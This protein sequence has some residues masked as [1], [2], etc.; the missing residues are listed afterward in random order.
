MLSS[1][2]AK[3]IRDRWIGMTIGAITMALFLLYGMAVYR[4]LDLS[5]YADMPES[6]RMLMNIPA[7]LDASQLAY[8]AVYG[9]V[10][11]MTLASLAIGMGSSSITGEE[12]KGTIGI[13][14]ANPKSRTH[15]LVS[16]AAAMLMITAFGAAILWAAGRLTPL[17][18]DVDVSAMQVEALIVHMYANAVFYGFLAMM[19]G[20]WSGKGT[21]ATGTAATV[22]VV[23]Y[24][25]VGILPLVE[26][27]EN[28]AKVF[29]WYYY[30]SSRPVDNG[31]DWGHLGVL[32][33]ATAVFAFV[34]YVG[35][36]RRDLRGPTTGVTLLDRLRNHPLTRKVVERLAGSARVSHIWVKTAS[37]H[38]GMLIVTSLIMI[39]IGLMVGPMYGMMDESLK[40]FSEQLPEALMAMVGS[41]DMGTPEGFFQAET[42]SLV[43]PVACIT[44]TAAI[45]ARALAGEEDRNT[46]GLLLANPIRRSRIV[47]EKAIAMV[48]HAVAFGFATFA[49]TALGSLVGGLGMDMGH[50]AA[51]S[52]L[53]TLVGLVFG[54][55]A[56][57]IGAATGR[58]RAA[59][60]GAAGLGLA[61]YFVS[62][63]LPLSD[64]LAGL[65]EWSPFHYYLSSD[66]LV[67]GM[68]WGHGALLA[69]LSAVLVLLS[70]V[71]FE[72]RDL[73]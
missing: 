48:V 72:R 53:L 67:N 50:I 21:A 28:L 25:A 70:A 9:M 58:V 16:K 29:P 51:A 56:L 43:G 57:A 52:L 31:F 66:P 60:Y 18:L 38:Q 13:L 71:L 15:V 27:W 36:N 61:A 22:M 47:V 37:E 30:D 1:V 6:L 49:G 3:A 23:S 73:R 5:L 26:G 42:F 11:A 4:E 40:D 12:R 59:A 54:L 2:F 19:I 44:L 10:G 41:V 45:G 39:L 17:L 35:V 20:A 63:F 55:A 46:M 24:F 64:S 14:L 7:D 32:V 8:G 68:H 34:A 62:S 33:G 69:G 65:A